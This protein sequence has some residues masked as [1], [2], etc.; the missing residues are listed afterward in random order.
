VPIQF[1]EERIVEARDRW[2]GN[3]RREGGMKA[4]EAGEIVGKK[5]G[6]KS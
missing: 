6:I 1:E 4:K 5:R 2:G 3:G